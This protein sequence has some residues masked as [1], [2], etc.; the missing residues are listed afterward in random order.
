ML[1]SIGADQL[2]DYT[3]EDYTKTGQRYDLIMD[4]IAKRSVF[5]Y[6]RAL[7]P[8]G[9]FVIVGGTL[10]TFLQVIILGALISRR[11]SKKFRINPWKQNK[12]E[13][14]AFLTELFEVG[15][16]VPIIDREFPLHEVPEALRYLGGGLSLG[17]VVITVA[18][19]NQT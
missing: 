13:D 12:E 15:K 9:I 3:Q 1:R 6:E 5:D 8:E 14:L 4:V 18:D 19:D 16:V 10:A 7:S 2:I 17:K 11:S